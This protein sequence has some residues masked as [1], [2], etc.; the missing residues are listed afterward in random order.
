MFAITK[1]LEGQDVKDCGKQDDGH[2]LPGIGNWE[3][4]QPNKAGKPTNRKD[5]KGASQRLQALP[6]D[7]ML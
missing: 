2:I 5:L 4:C 6:T 1:Q 7:K 3:S